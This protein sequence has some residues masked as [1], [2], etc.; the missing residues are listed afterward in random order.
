MTIIS[1]EAVLCKAEEEAKGMSEP[2]NYE[3]A[4]LVH[5]ILDKIPSVEPESKWIPVSERLPDIPDG[6]DWVRC[7]CYGEKEI[8]PDHVDDS[9]TITRIEIVT[10]FRH[11]GWDGWFHP[12]AWMPLP[13]PYKAESEVNADE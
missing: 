12:M 11:Y 10:Y 2:Y 1:K 13:E 8:T 3:F 9:N 5:W 4:P 6:E 7:L